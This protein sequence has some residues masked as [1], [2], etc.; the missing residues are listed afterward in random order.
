MTNEQLEAE[1]TEL[2]AQRLLPALQDTTDLFFTE[3]VSYG[4]HIPNRDAY[5]KRVNYDQLRT[6][7]N[8]IHPG[9]SRLPLHRVHSLS[10]ACVN[11]LFD[12]GHRSGRFGFPW[13]RGLYCD[14]IFHHPTIYRAMKDHPDKTIHIIKSYITLTNEQ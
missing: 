11:Q 8:R 4:Q 1:H 9:S 2:L 13:V 3:V 12:T 5:T 14:F 7:K 6:L 10:L